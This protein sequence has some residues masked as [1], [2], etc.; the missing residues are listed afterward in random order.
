MM[1]PWFY[2]AICLLGITMLAGQI[3][4]TVTDYR[5]PEKTNT[6][7]HNLRETRLHYIEN[8]DW[9]AGSWAYANKA[10]YFY[11]DNGLPEEIINYYRN[12][13]SWYY[14]SR[15]LIGYDANENWNHSVI[16]V[17]AGGWQN[18]YQI[19]LTWDGDEVQDVLVQI[20]DTQWINHQYNTY[21]YDDDV[22]DEVLIQNWDGSSWFNVNLFEYEYYPS[23]LVHYLITSQW[24]GSGWYLSY[25]DSLA[26]DA[27][28]NCTLV[29]SQT[30]LNNNWIHDEQLV[31]SYD[32]ANQINTLQQ[33][34]YIDAWYNLANTDRSFDGSDVQEEVIQ[35]WDG[36]MWQNQSRN[37]YTYETVGAGHAVAPT[38]Q[39][40]SYPNPFVVSS[41]ARDAGVVFAAVGRRDANDMKLKLYD[42]RGRLVRSLISQDAKVRWDGRDTS[43]TLLS[44]G[45]Y[46][47]R[48]D[49]DGTKSLGKV[50]LLK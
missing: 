13:N 27:A 17:W 38:M 28:G 23:E 8:F 3:N 11:G 12:N 4:D 6:T 45:V 24:D 30:H 39:V 7:L 9:D 33:Y 22:L 15:E 18:Y 19:M 48:A 47:Y 26:W 21:F 37:L 1:K 31:H 44:G 49:V 29:L 20:Y 50:L 42:S 16:Q 32:G 36:T 25:R 34:W 43:G 2:V 35:Q 5:H 40:V 41:N 46:F 10:E 14:A